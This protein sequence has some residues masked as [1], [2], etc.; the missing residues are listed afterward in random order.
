MK[1]ISPHLLGHDDMLELI[2]IGEACGTRAN[3]NRYYEQ[4][5]YTQPTYFFDWLMTNFDSVNEFFA[6]FD[7]KDVIFDRKNIA[8][9]LRDRHQ[10]IFVCFKY[11]VSI[12][13]GIDNNSSE[14]DY[15]QFIAKYVRR[16]DRLIARIQCINEPI[17]FVHGGVVT[18]DH[19]DTF[20]AHIDR[21]APGHGNRLLIVNDDKDQSNTIRC[22]KT[23]VIYRPD[24]RI[25]HVYPTWDQKEFDWVGIISTM[26]A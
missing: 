23:K 17:V 19:V 7:N 9:A 11:M 13:D 10:A 18:Q 24:F 16:Y 6:L 25:P 12:H 3:I 4:Y 20:W 22:D 5:G 15:T 21:I 8:Y 14:D 1:R 26:H 2:S